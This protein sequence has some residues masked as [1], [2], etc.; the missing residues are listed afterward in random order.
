MRINS[1]ITI[2]L[3]NI[4]LI[5]LFSSNLIAG[6]YMEEND[7]TKTYISNGKL[8]EISEDEGM[9]MDSESG[10]FIYFS[11]QRKTYTQGK[12][13]DFCASMAE[14][15]N[16]MMESMPPEYKKMMGVGKEKKPPKVEIISE[17]DGGIIAGYKTVKYKVLADGKLHEIMWLTMDASLVKEFKSLVGMLSEFEKCSKLMEFGAPPVGLSPEYLKLMEKGLTLKSIEYVNGNEEEVT[18][19][20]KV[21]IRDISVTEFQV[22]AGYKKMT[23]TDYFGS[24]MESDM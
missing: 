4:F 5:I 20:V 23:M 17:G 7:G 2:V 10:D 8:K 24:Q 16:K 9:I 3:I 21:E 11:P 22:P 18:N 19:T 6:I 13:S 12:I 15:M 14:V 1:I